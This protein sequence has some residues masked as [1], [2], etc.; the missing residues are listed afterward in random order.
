VDGTNRAQVHLMLAKLYEHQL[1]SL[2]SALSHAQASLGAEDEDEQ[3]RRLTRLSRKLESA[4]E[5][6]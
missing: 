3:K 4:G 5:E 1:R 2:N 6:V